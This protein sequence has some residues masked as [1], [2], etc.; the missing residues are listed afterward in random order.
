MSIEYKLAQRINPQNRSAPPKF[1]AVVQNTGQTNQR[2]LAEE[3]ARES[4]LSVGDIYSTI[5]LLAELIG[6]E[7]EKGK[8]VDLGELGRFGLTLR[9][10]GADTQEAYNTNLIKQVAIQFKPHK[11]LKDRVNQASFK[12]VQ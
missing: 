4:S 2:Q 8:I 12:R 10:S 7:L 6:R 3:I 9:G 5:V 11:R 1:Y